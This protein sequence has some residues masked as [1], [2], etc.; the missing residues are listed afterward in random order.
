[1]ASWVFR[2]SMDHDSVAVQEHEHMQKKQELGQY[3]AILA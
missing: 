2:G 3:L 1:M